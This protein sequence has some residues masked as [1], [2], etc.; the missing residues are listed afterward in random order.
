M[1]TDKVPE[2]LLSSL[3]AEVVC[4][5]SVKDPTKLAAVM[6]EFVQLGMA[7]ESM[8]EHHRQYLEP[9]V[10]DEGQVVQLRPAGEEAA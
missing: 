3:S 2:G 10:I 5:D 1:Y 9:Q 8:L 6:H 4:S 7:R